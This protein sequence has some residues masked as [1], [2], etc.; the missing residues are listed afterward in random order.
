MSEPAYTCDTC[1]APAP[2]V[3][4]TDESGPFELHC[5]ECPWTFYVPGEAKARTRIGKVRE[6]NR[7]GMAARVEG[8]LVDI[9][10]ANLL[11]TVYDALS[12]ASRE[13]FG[14]PSL[15]KL[16]DFSWKAVR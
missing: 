15:P 14:K 1:G 4:D 7:T 12:P 13:L 8:Y 5:S 3:Y 11:V 6:I 10:T 16:V 9:V 2:A